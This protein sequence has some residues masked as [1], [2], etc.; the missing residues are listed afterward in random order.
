VCVLMMNASIVPSSRLGLGFSKEEG[1]LPFRPS[2][3]FCFDALVD[4][5]VLARKFLGS[6]VGLES[7]V[8]REYV[9][10]LHYFSAAEA[11]AFLVFA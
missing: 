8:V 2:S 3:S 9:V 1:A 11:S 5:M 6:A 7:A 10:S 4:S